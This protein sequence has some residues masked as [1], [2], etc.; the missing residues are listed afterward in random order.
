M[1]QVPAGSAA[2]QGANL[3]VTANLP[4]ASIS[5]DGRS[6]PNWVTPY[7]FEDVAPGPHQVVISKPGFADDRRSLTLEGGKSLLVNGALSPATRQGEIDISTVPEGA[8]VLVDGRS[9]G[10]SPVQAV[11]SAGR[12]TFTVRQPGN[13]P[14]QGTVDVKEGSIV[15]RRLTWNSH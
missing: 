13:P 7:T 5:L 6:E 15:T 1:D 3:V 12:H 14:Y 9:Y 10:P 2:S 11:V 8:E 4:G